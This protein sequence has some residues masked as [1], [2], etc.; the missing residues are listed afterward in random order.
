[1]ATE[2]IMP[3]SGEVGGGVP[4]QINLYPGV[5]ELLHQRYQELTAALPNGETISETPAAMGFAER[6]RKSAKLARFSL[7]KLRSCPKRRTRSFS[8][9]RHVRQPLHGGTQIIRG[10]C[11][12]CREIAA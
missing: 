10:R 2:K 5:A 11:A 8:V 4:L 3:L 9:V 12:Y 1:V 7:V 6:G